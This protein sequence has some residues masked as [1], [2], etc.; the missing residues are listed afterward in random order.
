MRRHLLRCTSS[1]LEPLWTW[2]TG[3]RVSAQPTWAALAH[4]FRSPG[5]RGACH[6][7]ASEIA[8][9]MG[10]AFDDPLSP[11]ILGS[12]TR[13]EFEREV[14]EQ[15]AEAERQPQARR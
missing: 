7:Y 6:H 14:A 3:R 4:S 15:Q 5:L 12:D 13:R 11:P 1:P 2:R 9:V 10:R 8:L